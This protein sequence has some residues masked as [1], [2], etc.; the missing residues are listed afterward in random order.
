MRQFRDMFEEGELL[1]RIV[2]GNVAVG[3]AAAVVV[4]SAVVVSPVGAGTSSVPVSNA[5]CCFRLS[6]PGAFHASAPAAHIHNCYHYDHRR[7][8]THRLL[9]RLKSVT[10]R[11]CLLFRWCTAP[12]WILRRSGSCRKTAVS[13]FH[14]VHKFPHHFA[15]EARLIH[16][17]GCHH[18]LPVLL[19]VALQRRRKVGIVVG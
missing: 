15:S 19:L 11:W 4:A 9:D 5:V 1:V 6:R 17:H 13:S 14:A 2:A 8:T 16:R 12:P 18:S 7:N 10:A 3:N